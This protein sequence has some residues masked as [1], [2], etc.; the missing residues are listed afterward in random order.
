MSQ[1]SRDYAREK[2]SRSLDTI[3]VHNITNEDIV[4]WT[5]KYGVSPAKTLVPSQQ[6][7]IGFGKGN[8]HIARYRAEM[9]TEDL[10]TKV[11]NGISDEAWAKRKKEL[12][13]LPKDELLQ[14][15]TQEPMRTND[16]TMWEKLFSQIWLGVVEKFGNTELPEPIEDRPVDTGSAMGDVLKKSGLADKPYEPQTESH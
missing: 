14:I 10:I 1:A 15:A 12:R 11:I 8:N 3:C 16:R 13:M 5:D 6:K 2:T 7:D 4:F 9:F